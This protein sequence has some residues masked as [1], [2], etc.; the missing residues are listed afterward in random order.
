MNFVIKQV[1]EAG[2][3]S[4]YDGSIFVADLSE[5]KVVENIQDARYL[6]GVFQSQFIKSEVSKVSASVSVSLG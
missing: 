2:E 5:A 4:F 6:Q 1:N 3:V